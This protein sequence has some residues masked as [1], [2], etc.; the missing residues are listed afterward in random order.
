MYLKELISKKL[1][2]ELKSLKYSIASSLLTGNLYALL[3]SHSSQQI[4]YYERGIYMTNLLKPKRILTISVL[5]LFLCSGAIGA[6]KKPYGL[7][8]PISSG[9]GG[10][11]RGANSLVIPLAPEDGGRTASERPTFYWYLPA[12]SN[13]PYKTIFELRDPSDRDGNVV[14]RTEGVAAKNG[15][16]KV[17]L[18]QTSPS[19]K[20]EKIYTWHLRL[21]GSN[22]SSNIQSIGSIML[23]NTD[24]EIQKE[25]SQ[26]TTSLEK[27]KVYSRYGYWFDALN[28]YTNQLE[29]D[30]NNQTASKMRS[31]MMLEAF[32]PKDA[33]P[34]TI[35]NT[36]RLVENINR[37]NKIEVLSPKLS[38]EPSI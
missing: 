18:P 35:S 22:A 25:I 7:G 19:L 37:S 30:P 34:E 14:F 3:I 4:N 11:V 12:N 10:A 21:R 31:E 8:V 1:D 32:T 15:L 20:P 17:T 38:I 26:A 6:P 29:A 36:K 27:A 23:S 9:T 33:D 28:I 5:S 24:A 2:Y 16:Y 13:F